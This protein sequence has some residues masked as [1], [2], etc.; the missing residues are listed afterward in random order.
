MVPGFRIGDKRSG[1]SAGI[2][3]DVDRDLVLGVGAQ[4][5]VKLYAW[6]VWANPLTALC[7]SAVRR[8][9]GADDGKE[10]VRAPDGRV[11]LQP[12]VAAEGAASGI[13]WPLHH[14]L[15]EAGIGGIDA[16][17]FPSEDGAI[18]C[19]VGYVLAGGNEDAV[20]GGT[21]LRGRGIR[22]DDIRTIGVR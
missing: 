11:R 16:V 7:C 19:P 3:A 8:A 13:E 1:R 20:G 10:V 2:G 14:L 17:R 18:E 5:D 9:G 22:P 15:H 4:D 21:D 12:V 6:S